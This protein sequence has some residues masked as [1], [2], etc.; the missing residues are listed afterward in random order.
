M[1]QKLKGGDEYDC[2]SRWRKRGYLNR[3]TGV[4]KL[5]KRGMNKRFRKEGKACNRSQVW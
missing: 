5:V 3:R 1:K 2:V 4:W